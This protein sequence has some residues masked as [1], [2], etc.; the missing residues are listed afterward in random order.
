MNGF[1]EHQ[2]SDAAELEHKRDVVFTWEQAQSMLPLIN[3]IVNDLLN[4]QEQLRS[5]EKEKADLDRRRHSL[6]WPA[7]SRRYQLDDEIRRGQKHLKEVCVELQELGV[8]L[9]DADL[10]QVGYPTVVNNRHA[11]FSWRTG[12]SNVDHWHFTQNLVRRPVPDS[13]KGQENHVEAESK[14]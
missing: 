14:S 11:F 12:E 10:G 4:T 3:H 2:E 6:D 1:T 8:D 13:W 5:W 7:R 9:I